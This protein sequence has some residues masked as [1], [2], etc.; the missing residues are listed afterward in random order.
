MAST[1]MHM[2]IANEIYKRIKDKI[3]INYYDYILGTIAPDISK[4][5]GEPRTISHFID[6]GNPIPNIDKFLEKYMPTIKKSFNLGYFIHLYADKLFYGDYLPLFI[7]TDFFSSTIRRLDGEKITMSRTEQQRILYNDYTNLNSLLIDEYQL[8][9]D[10]FYNEFIIPNTNITEIPV[11]KLNLLIDNAGIIIQNLN[12]QKEY[13]IDITS[14]KAFIDD[15][16][17]EIYLKLISLGVI[18]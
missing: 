11:N 3:N 12:K 4:H 6:E 16:I 14:I 18:D 7:K 2:A 13:M 1:V 8:S 9:L 15:C 17:E 10:L 5:I